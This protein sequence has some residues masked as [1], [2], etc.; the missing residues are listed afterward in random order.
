ME[1]PE[2][3]WG[4]RRNDL[5]RAL[6]RVDVVLGDLYAQVI[7]ALDRPLTVGRLVVASHCVREI[8]NNLVDHLDD[9]EGL[10][11]Y[12][13][14]SKHRQ[15][16]AK[17]WISHEALLGPVDRPTDVAAVPS[18]TGPANLMTV[19][20]DLVERVRLVVEVEIGGTDRAGMRLSAL[21]TGQ[22][23][24]TQSASV[25]LLRDTLKFFQSFVHL[26]HG[27][28]IELPDRGEVLGHLAKFEEALMGRV[29]DFFARRSDILDLLER[30]N[31]RTNGGEGTK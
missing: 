12:V 23:D 8:A 1:Q 25:R 29:G 19:P 20:S 14:G 31:Q 10:P 16:L 13:D 9:V 5:R 30:A 17:S 24:H 27:E 15:N 6:D 28:P 3:L 21:M 18:P 2:S 11:E 4:H 7:D 26:R 22:L